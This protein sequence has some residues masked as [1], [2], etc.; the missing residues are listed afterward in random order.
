MTNI[1]PTE[2]R[3]ALMYDAV[4]GLFYRAGCRD[5]A[6]TGRTDAKG[7]VRVSYKGKYYF[8]HRLAWLYVFNEWPKNIIDHIN[9]DRADNRLVN[10]RDV[11]SSVNNLNRTLSTV[12]SSKSGVKGVTKFVRASG[13]VRYQAVICRRGF[14]KYLGLFDTLEAASAAYLKADAEFSGMT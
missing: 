11:T 5:G 9:R 12:S 6:P 3:A 14:F 8:A 4:S 10:L 13:K 1:N 7:Y 2:L